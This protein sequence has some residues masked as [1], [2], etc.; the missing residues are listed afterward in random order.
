[1]TR[2]ETCETISVGAAFRADGVEDKEEGELK[3]AV[4][5]AVDGERMEAHDEDASDATSCAD[6]SC[7]S[8]GETT[9]CGA[10]IAGSDILRGRCGGGRAAQK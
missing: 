10:T 1:M 8:S 4:V 9:R 3:A 7:A 5:G 6:T 2:L